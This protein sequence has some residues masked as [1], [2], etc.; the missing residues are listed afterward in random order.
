MQLF[1]KTST[2]I[3]SFVCSVF[4]IG[5]EQV[6]NNATDNTANKTA[7]ANESPDHVNES[8]S[9][10]TLGK[11]SAPILLSHDYDGVSHV[12]EIENFSLTITSAEAG[13]LSVTVT[14]KDDLLTTGTIDQQQTVTAQEPMQ[15]P[16]SL[17][18]PQNGKYYLSINTTLTT[19]NSANQSAQSK[20]FSIAISTPENTQE[21]ISDDSE[22]SKPS[23]KIFEAEETIRQ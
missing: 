19:N 22:K 13:T 8:K 6:N 1:K 5:C 10:H 2:L 3:I 20:A 18:V 9:A 7:H 21:K 14:S 12:G 15:V 16:V 17:S 11:P 23:I 4:I